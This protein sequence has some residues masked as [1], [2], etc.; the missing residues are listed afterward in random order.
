[1]PL[2]TFLTRSFKKYTNLHCIFIGAQT[3]VCMY[4]SQFNKIDKF[5][6]IHIAAK[7]NLIQKCCVPKDEYRVKKS[8]TFSVTFS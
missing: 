5:P 3:H 4:L 2:L 8:E 6:W 1:M 7:C